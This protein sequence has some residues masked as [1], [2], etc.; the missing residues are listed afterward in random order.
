MSSQYLARANAT[1]RRE[2]DR[3]LR[4]C[5]IEG[6][7]SLDISRGEQAQDEQHEENNHE[8]EE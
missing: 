2:Q 1:L 5:N 3:S 4:I 6:R 7:N 8:N